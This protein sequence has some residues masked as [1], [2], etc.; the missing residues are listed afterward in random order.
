VRGKSW[1]KVAKQQFSDLPEDY[2]KAWA[3][4]RKDI[5]S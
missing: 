5:M 1:D 2:K 3:D 4:L